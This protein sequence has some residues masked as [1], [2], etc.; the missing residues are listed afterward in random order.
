MIVEYI[1]NQKIVEIV[2]HPNQK[3]YPEQNIFILNIQE[4]IHMVPYVEN[5]EEIFLKT[6]IPSRKLT[7]AYLGEKNE[8]KK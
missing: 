1:S 2:K 8:K 3:K 7:K 4:Y 5:E 6:I